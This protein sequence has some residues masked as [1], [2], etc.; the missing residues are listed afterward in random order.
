MARTKISTD[1]AI[2][3]FD[4]SLPKTASARLAVSSE[5]E[6]DRRMIAIASLF[7]GFLCDCFRSR[8]RLETEILVLRHQLNVLQQR[9]APSWMPSRPYVLKW[10]LSLR[11]AWFRCAI[12][13]Q[14]RG[15][16]WLTE[17][18]QRIV[19]RMSGSPAISATGAAIGVVCTSA[20]YPDG[21][22]RRPH[23]HGPNPSLI[24]NLPGWLLDACGPGVR[25]RKGK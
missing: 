23:L 17:E 5:S 25:L 20:E 3:I 9:V 14:P 4:V 19:G 21:A 16:L 8:R 11:G 24:R 15:P 12:E 2:D 6:H 1:A 10:L 13:A 22:E 7:V 18:E